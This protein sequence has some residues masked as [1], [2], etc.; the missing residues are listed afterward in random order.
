MLSDTL[1]ELV[2]SFVRSFGLHEPDRTPCGQPVS[3]S[4]AHALAEL[5]KSPGLSQNELASRLKLEKSTVSRLINSMDKRNW[6]HRRKDGTDSRVWRL[7]LTEQGE[8]AALNIEKARR[9]KFRRVADAISSDRMSIVE[10]GLRQLI[11]AVQREGDKKH[12]K[13]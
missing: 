1:Q 6:V 5:L 3:V 10:D 12:D 4:E 8:N 7:T 9:D 2:M 13:A 11:Q